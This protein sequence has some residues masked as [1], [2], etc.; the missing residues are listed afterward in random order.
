M[1]YCLKKSVALGFRSQLVFFNF[2]LVSEGDL[3]Y[4]VVVRSGKCHV[5]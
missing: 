3:H 4:I 2:E 1:G 5:S